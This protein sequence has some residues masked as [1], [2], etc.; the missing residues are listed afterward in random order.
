M[1]TD[2]GTVLDGE[3][4]VKEGLID[5]VGSLSEALDILYAMIDEERKSPR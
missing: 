1:A 2:V 5:G 4:A 3:A